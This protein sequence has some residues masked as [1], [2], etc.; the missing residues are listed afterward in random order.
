MERIKSVPKSENGA[1]D[2]T[3]EALG[4]E[5]LVDILAHSKPN[6]LGSGY[7]RMYLVCALIFLTSTMNGKHCGSKSLMHSTAHAHV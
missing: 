2:N 5:K 6:W 7:L 3:I 1:G 4:D